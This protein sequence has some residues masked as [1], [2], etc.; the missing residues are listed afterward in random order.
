MQQ[1]RCRI[2]QKQATLKNLITHRVNLGRLVERNST[3]QVPEDHRYQLPLLFLCLPQ[4]AKMTQANCRA[5]LNIQ[6][7]QIGQVWDESVILA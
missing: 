5:T 7:D 3:A 2:A 1:H 6:T 4:D